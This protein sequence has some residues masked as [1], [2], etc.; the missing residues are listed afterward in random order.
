M[1]TYTI[2]QEVNPTEL[3][4]TVPSSLIELPNAMGDHALIDLT[5]DGLVQITE[6][7]GAKPS[8]LSAIGR[9]LG[10]VAA[11]L[12]SPDGQVATGR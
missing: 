1:T 5:G 10:E 4:P 12:N 7:T 2:T 11:T 3:A 8:R 9:A 6:V